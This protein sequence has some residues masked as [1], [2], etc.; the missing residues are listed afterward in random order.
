M[1]VFTYAMT[2]SE[3]V[4]LMGWS[5][6][7][8]RCQLSIV[9]MYL[10]TIQIRLTWILYINILHIRNRYIYYVLIYYIQSIFIYVCI[11]YTYVNTIKKNIYIDTYGYMYV[12]TNVC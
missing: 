9:H 8:Q 5:K 1:Y 4:N 2:L 6:W 7:G 11:V 12:C 3:M 10:Y